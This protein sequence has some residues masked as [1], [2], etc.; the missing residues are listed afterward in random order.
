M[1]V[2]AVTF[3]QKILK[4]LHP[5]HPF[6]RCP[7]LIDAVVDRHVKG[8]V[9][10]RADDAVGVQTMT[11]LKSLDGFLQRGSATRIRCIW[12]VGYA[13]PA[14]Q[15][16]HPRVVV[17]LMQRCTSRDCHPAGSKPKRLRGKKVPTL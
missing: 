9:G 2:L 16:R 6:Q 17:P 7:K 11:L 10:G 5:A 14:P 1:S 4:E 3:T 15:R 8:L 12:I 13:Q